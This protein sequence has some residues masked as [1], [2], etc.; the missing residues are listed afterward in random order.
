M[1]ST[2]A[3]DRYREEIARIAE[4]PWPYPEGRFAG[5]GIV[6]CAGGRSYYTCAWVLVNV[7]R[8]LGCRLPIEVWHRGPAEMSDPMVRLLESV[9]GTRCVDTSHVPGHPPAGRLSGW[10]IKPFAI[11]HSRFEHVLFI[12]CD[13][14]P[15][16]DP[17][18]LLESEPYR[19]TGAIFWPDR[20]MREGDPYRTLA[21]GAWTACG[22]PYREEPEVESG[23]MVLH[24]RRCWRALQLAQFYNDRSEFFYEL[25][26]GDKDTYH[27]AWRRTG[28]DYAMP[29]FRPAQDWEDGPVLYQHD[30]QGRRLFQHRNQ[31][32]WDYDGGN[33]RIPGFQHEQR[34]FRYL[35]ELRRRWDGVVRRYPDDY[36]PAERAAYE[37][38]TAARLLHYG[39]DG[40]ESRLLEFRP[41]FSL[42]VGRSK[43]ETDWEL[44][45]DEAGRVRL[46][47]SSSLRKMCILDP[48]DGDSWGGRCLHFERQAIAIRP[49]ARLPLG[50]RAVAE[51]IRDT[52]A[53]LSGRHGEAVDQITSVRAFVYHGPDGHPRPM[54]FHDDHTIGTG[55]AA[56]EQ[57]WYLDGAADAP[58]LLLCGHHGPTACLRRQ[59]DASWAGHSLLC[60]EAPVAL[61]PAL[62]ARP[63]AEGAYYPQAQ[64]ELSY[65]PE[66]R[67]ALAYYAR[68][69]Q[70]RAYYAAPAQA[71]A[72]YSRGGPTPAYY[73]RA[74]GTPVYYARAVPSPTYYSQPAPSLAYYS[75][76]DHPAA[77]YSRPALSLAYYSRADQPLAYYSRADRVPGYYAPARASL[78]Y[79]SRGTDSA[80]PPPAPPG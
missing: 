48:A 32:K 60:A 21:D 71:P 33:V 43:W 57:W 52:L 78:D 67:P 80:D 76:A 1:S 50:A 63:G 30:F 10:Q 22:V 79:Y 29:P 34:C 8:S 25:L 5:A 58:T 15:T 9:Q 40:I 31:D 69:G 59:P 42:G 2:D 68:P 41:D 39:Y 72:Y 77:Y 13:N 44:E 6:T 70:A 28:H 26:L 14:V 37:R 4:A 74:D 19:R 73:A 20:W 55:A 11:V 61:V 51:Q 12:D 17:S 62:V 54:V 46:I 3:I 75:R 45:E 64:E 65:Y 36:T 56:H 16:R 24:K 27:M 18:F 53:H 7:L 23:Q 35:D 47:L 49:I 66:G 38:I